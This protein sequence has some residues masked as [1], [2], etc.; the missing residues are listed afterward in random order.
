[1]SAEVETAA[2]S[3][4]N[5]FSGSEGVQDTRFCVSVHVLYVSLVSSVF[6]WQHSSEDQTLPSCKKVAHLKASDVDKGR[7]VM[8]VIDQNA[9]AYHCI[10]SLS[11]F[12]ITDKY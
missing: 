1:M 7:A 2:C 10:S 8:Q 11:C 4:V 12:I 5:P 6:S 9:V 3:G